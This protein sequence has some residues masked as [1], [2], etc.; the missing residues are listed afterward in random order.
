[1]TFY[2]NQ[3]SPILEHSWHDGMPWYA[4]PSD[5]QNMSFLKLCIRQCLKGATA[6]I[7]TSRRDTRSGIM[8]CCICL[9]SPPTTLKKLSQLFCSYPSHPHHQYPRCKK[10]P[11]HFQRPP[12][13]YH[14]QLQ[15]HLAL[16]RHHNGVWFSAA[17]LTSCA[18]PLPTFTPSPLIYF[19]SSAASSLKPYTTSLPKPLN[20]PQQNQLTPPKILTPHQLP[21][22]QHG[23]ASRQHTLCDHA[24]P[25]CPGR[26]ASLFIR[27]ITSS[28]SS[29]V[30]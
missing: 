6:V 8:C 10:F 29:S 26:N 28:R 2:E 25:L 12:L 16:R 7:D 15:W 23:S 1:M 9:E 30:T 4:I 13:S 17:L 19:P 18:A 5:I 3:R 11:K 24:Q 27:T 21:W 20:P 14:R 22:Y